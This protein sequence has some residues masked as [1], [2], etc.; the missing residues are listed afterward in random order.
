MQLVLTTAGIAALTNSIPPVLTAFKLGSGV[1]FTPSVSDTDIH[2]SVVNTGAPSEATII[3]PNLLRYT[4][5]VDPTAGPFNF[6]EV[7]LYLAG[8]VLFALGSFSTLQHKE[9]SSNLVTGGNLKIDCYVT[10]I[11]NSYAVLADATNTVGNVNLPVLS[12]VDA[13]PSPSDTNYN[14]YVCLT[15]IDQYVTTLATAEGNF[16]SFTGYES[17]RLTAAITSASNSYVNTGSDCGS[18]SYAGEVILQFVSGS[19]RGLVRS[20]TSITLSGTRVNFSVPLLNVPEVGAQFILY[21]RRLLNPGLTSL[22]SSLSPT[23]TAG[24][25]NQLDNV[26]LSDLVRKDGSST[27]TGS[28]NMGNQRLVNVG[29]PVSTGD[30]VNKTY[31]DNVLN[32]LAGAVNNSATDIDYL[33]TNAI[34]RNGSKVMTNHLQMGFNSVRNMAPP[35]YD[36]DAANAQWV[37]GQIAAALNTFAPLHNNLS[38]LQGG[39]TGQMYHVTTAE[40]VFLA[41]VV[42]SGLPIASTTGSGLLEIA[43]TTEVGATTS[44]AHALTPSNLSAVLITTGAPTEMHK[45]ISRGNRKPLIHVNREG[46]GTA[47]PGAGFDYNQWDYVG[48]DADGM[49]GFATTGAKAAFHLITLPWAGYYVARV[50]LSYGNNTSGS[51]ISATWAIYNHTVAL[52]HPV[53]A[54]P[55]IPNNSGGGFQGS[56]LLGIATTNNQVSLRCTA[57]SGTMPN[58][59]TGTYWSI[60]WIRPV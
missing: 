52:S 22:L 21:Q 11:G 18:V 34:V 44:N 33:L 55:S 24:D 46:A 47:H 32:G 15:N 19:H 60:E 28:L 20:V 43:D 17:V 4:I 39:Q 36:F 37:N 57:S 27:M 50:Y 30:A 6:G 1:N 56:S 5:V 59:L 3:N 8:N 12:S 13:L 58:I 45:A 38:G 23:L 7:G 29:A 31:V 49:C 51:T 35:T 9:P 10:V 48:V 2:G 16:W 26:V 54:S 25:L 53:V 14:T 40:K 42:N 41:N